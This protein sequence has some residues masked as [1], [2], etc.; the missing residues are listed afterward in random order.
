[1]LCMS[2]ND[3]L[4]LCFHI[5][6]HIRRLRLGVSTF[7]HLDEAP[8]SCLVCKKKDFGG[9]RVGVSVVY[10]VRWLFGALVVEHQNLF[11][12]E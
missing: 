8:K 2:L 11:T 3:L 5:R 7:E 4:D 10:M 1:M 12:P 9:S 6:P